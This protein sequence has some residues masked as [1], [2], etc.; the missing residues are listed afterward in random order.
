[1]NHWDT[2]H[3]QCYTCLFDERVTLW[4]RLLLKLTVA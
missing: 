4:S 1:M 3:D 2:D